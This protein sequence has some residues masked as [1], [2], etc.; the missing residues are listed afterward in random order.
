[1]SETIMERIAINN[2]NY[3]RW[4]FAYF[5]ESAKKLGVKNIELCGCHP[6][7]TMFEAEEFPVT[8]MAE[9]IK[10]AGLK[11]TAI[12]SE[13]NFL[14]INIA[15]TNAY[16]VQESIRQLTFYIKRAA[17]FDC[18]RV[19]LYPGKAF[20]DHPHSEGWK[21]ARESVKK[22]CAIARECQVTLLMNPVSAFVSDLMMD[23]NAVDRMLREVDA[24]N[25]GV[26]V[27]SG[28]LGYAGE[29]FETYFE[30]FGDKIGMIQ[31]SDSVEDCDQLAWGE[32]NQSLEKH[33]AILKKYRYEGPITMEL[34][35]EEYA[36]DPHKVHQ[37]SL[38]YM[39]AHMEQGEML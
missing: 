27:N 38:A 8:E 19:I 26:C 14:P 34:L 37:D 17:A 11:V 13:Q 21:N 25:L 3:R 36:E 33:L 30:K 32:G 10:K 9:K 29:T 28:V 22:L 2:F 5:L 6:H 18:T 39:R 16:L 31:L 1:M 20:M 24:D 7:F 15:A 4:S 23:S 12:E 35:M